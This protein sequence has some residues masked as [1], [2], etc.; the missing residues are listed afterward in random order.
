MVYGVLRGMR[1]IGMAGG[2]WEDSQFSVEEEAGE[3]VEEWTGWW[4][5][6]T[7]SET[8]FSQMLGRA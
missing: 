2:E 3:E 6:G 4:S 8:L 1:R 5:A 7:V